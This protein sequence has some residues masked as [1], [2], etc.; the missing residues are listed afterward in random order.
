MD[1]VATI[2]GRRIAECKPA[3]SHL[4]PWWRVELRGPRFGDSGAVVVW[5]KR[6]SLAEA[7]VEAERLGVLTDTPDDLSGD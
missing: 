7:I 2:N 1:L 6:D 3:G 4:Y 5:R